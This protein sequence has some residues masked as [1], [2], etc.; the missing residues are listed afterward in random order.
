MTEFFTLLTSVYLIIIFIATY[1]GGELGRG[2][3][4]SNSRGHSLHSSVDS[5]GSASG[6]GAAG[7]TRRARRQS[8][9]LEPL[10]GSTGSGKAVR[11][12]VLS[13]LYD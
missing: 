1:I 12:N 11:A 3:S 5:T 6:S 10:G 2:G 7:S 9:V 13:S 4:L 8:L